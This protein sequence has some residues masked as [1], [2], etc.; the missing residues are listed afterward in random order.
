[1]AGFRQLSLPVVP[2]L[3]DGNF[4][5]SNLR[6]RASGCPLSPGP[7]LDELIE[8][9]QHTTK[10]N[11]KMRIIIQNNNSLIPW[12][13]AHPLKK[14]RESI[15]NQLLKPV[16]GHRHC[17]TSLYSTIPEKSGPGTQGRFQLCVRSSSIPLTSILLLVSYYPTVPNI[18]E[19]T[20]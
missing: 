5:S 3:T 14:S 20:Y 15:L 12:L 7:I 4:P 9:V 16:Q 8:M 10:T 19:F 17:R 6:L 11:N 2:P 1:M 13:S 18:V